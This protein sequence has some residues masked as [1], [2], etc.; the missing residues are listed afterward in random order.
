MLSVT[1]SKTNPITT[2]PHPKT[3]QKKQT[4]KKK[5]QTNKTPPPKPENCQKAH[6]KSLSIWR[7]TL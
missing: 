1:Q 5:T 6:F 7:S 2:T 4:D 3:T